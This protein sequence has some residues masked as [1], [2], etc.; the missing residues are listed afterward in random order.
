MKNKPKCPVCGKEIDRLFYEVTGTK[1]WD[2]ENWIEDESEGNAEYT[3]P[4]C[5]SA[6][7][8]EELEA[9]GVF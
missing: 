7:D 8:Y 2:G 3:C 1:K 6:L 4:L 5:N 9:L